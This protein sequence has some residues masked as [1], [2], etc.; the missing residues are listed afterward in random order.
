MFEII[1]ILLLLFSLIAA[2]VAVETRDLLSAVI[3]LGVLGFGLAIIFLLLK[4]P[5]VMTAQLVVEILTFVMMVMTV[6]KTSKIDHTTQYTF[7]SMSAQVVAVVFFVAIF[8]IV[9]LP[10]IKALPEF[11]KP[12]MKV[13][14]IYIDKVLAEIGA[15]NI[16][17]AVL[18]DFRAYN[19]LM[20]AVI[21]ITMT[22]G[23]AVIMRKTGRK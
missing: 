7:R 14:S 15:T 13:S 12:V 19:T 11:G 1:L 22:V 6:Y 23:V 21:I 20:E 16:V 18:L 17:T 5:E 10:V 9:S 4:A 2:I 3:L 8:L